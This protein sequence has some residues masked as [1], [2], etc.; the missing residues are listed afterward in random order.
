MAIGATIAAAAAG[1]NVAGRIYLT[2]IYCQA[3]A[4]GIAG[5]T[6]GNLTAAASTVLAGII[7]AASHTAVTTVGQCIQSRLTTIIWIAVTVP[8]QTDTSR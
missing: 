2:A 4:V 6:R 8:P 5:I 1:A 7:Q 3:V